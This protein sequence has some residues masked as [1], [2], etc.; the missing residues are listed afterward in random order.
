MQTLPSARCEP[1]NLSFRATHG[2]GVRIIVSLCQVLHR[3][4]TTP[5]DYRVEVPP[6]PVRET[7]K[8][9]SPIDTLD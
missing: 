3:S 5:M 9:I 7:P 2:A 4:L 1:V 6:G 8:A